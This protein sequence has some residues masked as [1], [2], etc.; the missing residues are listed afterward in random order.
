MK[1]E[2]IPVVSYEATESKTMKKSKHTPEQILYALKQNE[3]GETVALCAGN[4]ESAKR[5]SMQA[6]PIC[7]KANKAQNY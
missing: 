4:W 6:N 5:P 1:L 3:S 2:G 7:D